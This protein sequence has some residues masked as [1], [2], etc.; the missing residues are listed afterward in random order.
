MAAAIG[1]ASFGFAIEDIVTNDPDK[2]TGTEKK[3][4]NIK[5]GALGG[6]GAVLFL[7]AC[8]WQLQRDREKWRKRN[9]QDTHRRSTNT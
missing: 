2:D 5:R 7:S 1:L 4:I 8:Y 3:D 9:N 6:G